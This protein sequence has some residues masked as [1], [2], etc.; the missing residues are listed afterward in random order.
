MDLIVS[1]L[2]WKLNLQLNVLLY[3]KI[4]TAVFE[5]TDSHRQK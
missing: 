2:R 1:V 5:D 3:L 4:Y